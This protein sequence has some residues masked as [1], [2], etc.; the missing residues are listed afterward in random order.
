MDWLFGIIVSISLS[1]CSFFILLGEIV[2][3][4]LSHA[5]KSISLDLSILD[6]SEG[7]IDYYIIIV[8]IYLRVVSSF[9]LLEK[10][11]DRY[12]RDRLSFWPRFKIDYSLDL[13]DSRSLDN[14]EGWI[15]YLKL[16]FL[17]I[18][19]RVFIREINAWRLS[20]IGLWEL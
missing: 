10:W 7:W 15:D 16:F 11:R 9:I 17:Y 14:S 2:H 19:L 8:Y 4:S 3:P 18:Y 1:T 5:L 13:Y 12:W 6:N 20:R